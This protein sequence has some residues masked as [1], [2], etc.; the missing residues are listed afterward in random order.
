[1]NEPTIQVPVKR[2]K[3]ILIHSWDLIPLDQQVKL[4]EMGIHP[5]T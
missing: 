1:M 5:E 4:I 3:A 2:F